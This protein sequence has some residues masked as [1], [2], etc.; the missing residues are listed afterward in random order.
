MPLIRLSR[1][2]GVDTSALVSVTA[3]PARYV[4]DGAPAGIQIPQQPLPLFNSIAPPRREENALRREA[5]K[6]KRPAQLF[7]ND[8]HTNPLRAQKERASQA[9]STVTTTT[10]PGDPPVDQLTPNSTT[11]ANKKK[12]VKRKAATADATESGDDD[13]KSSSKG[14]KDVAG[15]LTTSSGRVIKPKKFADEH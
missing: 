9:A 12:P 3:F 8:L 5:G 4:W 2:Q 11:G 10:S 6:R 15:R 14:S 13:C 7:N 1:R